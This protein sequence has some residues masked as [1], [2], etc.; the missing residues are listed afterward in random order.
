MEPGSKERIIATAR[1][2]LDR[3][4]DWRSLLKIMGLR[5]EDRIRMLETL[6]KEPIHIWLTKHAEQHVIYLSEKDSLEED[7]DIVP[8]QWK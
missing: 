4:V 3:F 2:N 5:F 1:K 8:Y 6:D 7:E